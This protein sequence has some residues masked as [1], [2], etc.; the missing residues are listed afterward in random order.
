M[1]D[2][3]QEPDEPCAPET[4]AA[5]IYRGRYVRTI[6]GDWDHSQ[7]GEIT[8]PGQEYDLVPGAGLLRA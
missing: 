4:E 3:F 2:D 8:E 1:I 5:V 7:C 6:G